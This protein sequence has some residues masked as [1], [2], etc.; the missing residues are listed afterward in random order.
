MVRSIAGTRKSL[1]PAGPVNAIRSTFANTCADAVS[2]GVLSAE[3]HSGSHTAASARSGVPAKHCATVCPGGV[4][5]LRAGETPEVV[6]ECQ[7]LRQ[8]KP[9]RREDSAGEM[10]RRRQVPRL[11]RD[12]ARG[13]AAERPHRQRQPVEQRGE[14]VPPDAR[15]R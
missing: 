2:G 14:R 9:A 4:R 1:S 6:D 10:E 12:A 7:P 11:Q 15:A 8:R 3:M 5:K 13:R